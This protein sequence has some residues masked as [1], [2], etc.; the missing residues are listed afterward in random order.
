MDHGYGCYFGRYYDFWRRPDDFVQQRDFFERG[1]DIIPL[2]NEQDANTDLTGDWCKLTNYHRAAILIAKY[3]TEDVDTLGFQIVQATAAAG[4]SSKKVDALYSY[5]YKQGTLTSAT[6]WTTGRL[7]TAD[8]ILGVGS[9][10]P[11]GGTLVD[12]GT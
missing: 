2:I 6:V 1:N 7:T 4:T 11:T 3:G 10:A 5:A 9:S 8:D 12:P